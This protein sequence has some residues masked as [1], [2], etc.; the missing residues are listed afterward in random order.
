MVP[1]YPRRYASVGARQPHWLPPE[2]PS[3]FAPRLFEFVGS[4]WTWLKGGSKLNRHVDALELPDGSYLVEV[5][6][7][8]SPPPTPGLVM[9]PST[10]RT[11]TVKLEVDSLAKVRDAFF[12]RRD[13]ERADDD[14][15]R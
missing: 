4:G 7:T 9:G 15:Y 3:A 14:P 11:Y 6:E 10:P 5:M 12:E 8:V 1:S 13:N 2:E